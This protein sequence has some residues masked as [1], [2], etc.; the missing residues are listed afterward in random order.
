MK[1][2]LLDLCIKRIEI[3]IMII[4]WFPFVHFLC[5]H[6]NFPSIYNICFLLIKKKNEQNYLSRVGR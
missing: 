5:T 4:T 2:N 3:I 1:M 6:G